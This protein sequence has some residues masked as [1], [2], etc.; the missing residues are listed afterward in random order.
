M[1]LENLNLTELNAQEM[2]DIEGGWIQVLAGGL[3][4][5]VLYAAYEIGKADAA[6]K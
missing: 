4:G 6:H 1:K 2:M 5:L 3:L